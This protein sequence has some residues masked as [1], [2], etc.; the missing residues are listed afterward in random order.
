M[1]DDLIFSLRKLLGEDVVLIPIPRGRKGPII[2]GW[3]H[4]TSEKMK[5]PEYLTQLNHGGNIG[6]LLGNGLVTIDLDHDAAVERFLDLYPELRETLRS[7]RV[8]GCN[9]WVQLR[10]DYPP[11]SR[12]WR[13][14][15]TD[16]WA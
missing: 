16:W 1:I 11:S 13:T 12:L 5:E 9:R 6:V 7:T 4:F 8:G 3:Q 15:G 14:R 10:V 2:E